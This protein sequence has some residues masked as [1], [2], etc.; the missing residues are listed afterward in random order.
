M[1]GCAYMMLPAL[2]RLA[3]LIALAGLALGLSACGGG[4]KEDRQAA[5][6]SGTPAGERASA[7]GATPPGA[8]PG[9]WTIPA[10]D[11]H[12]TRFSPLDQI[13]PGNVGRLRLAWSFSTG[14]LRGH[15]AA[16]IVAE[17]T[18]FVVTPWPNYLYAIDLSTGEQKWKYDP[19]TARAAQGVA[20]CDVVNRGAEG[21]AGRD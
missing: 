5:L 18:M 20:C 13:N 1:V 14:V 10:R 7:A 12:S 19:G 6:G 8:K 9:D 4:A 3:H 17:G 2:S 11:Y 15:E 16:P 21:Q